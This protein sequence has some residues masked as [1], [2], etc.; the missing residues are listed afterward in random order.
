MIQKVMEERVTALVDERLQALLPCLKNQLLGK[1]EISQKLDNNQTHLGFTCK[2]CNTT[3]VVGIR[4]ECPTCPNFNLCEVC[5]A[6]IE[7]NHAMLKIKKVVS[8]EDQKPKGN[9]FDRHFFKKLFKGHSSSSSGSIERK[10]HGHPH[11]HPHGPHPG[12]GGFGEMNPWANRVGQFWQNKKCWKLSQFF[13]GEP[14]KYQEFVKKHQELRGR[15]IIR[16][17]AKENNIKPEEIDEKLVAKRSKKLG[18]C[19][20]KPAESYVALV[21]ENMELNFRELLRLIKERNL[22]PESGK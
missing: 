19:F 12:F 3:P 5:E 7:H 1:A 10:Y 9:E 17:Y 4:Y 20:S 13:G 6:S 11:G 2:G 21:K 18:E 16:L 15:Q 8:V 14:S 22:E